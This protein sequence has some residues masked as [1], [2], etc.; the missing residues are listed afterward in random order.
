MILRCFG[1][2]LSVVLEEE[3]ERAVATVLRVD[4]EDILLELSCRVIVVV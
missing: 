1:D 3:E 2:G 4:F